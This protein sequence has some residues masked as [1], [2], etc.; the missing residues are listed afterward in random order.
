MTKSMKAGLYACAALL[1]TPAAAFTYTYEASDSSFIL[2]PKFDPNYG[3]LVSI[4]FE[5]QFDTTHFFGPFE[6]PQTI[7]VVGTVGDP[8]L[9]LTAVD[10]YLTS[11][12]SFGYNG[13]PLIAITL[14]TKVDRT[15]S[16]DLSAYYAGGTGFGGVPY[17]FIGDT[18]N[19]VFEL[20]NGTRVRDVAV[21]RNLPF[22]S[23]K[24]TYEFTQAAVVP[25][26]ATWALM[27][28][29][30]GMIGYSLRRRAK[31]LYAA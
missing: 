25:E 5:N 4:R 20:P 19:Q 23:T 16:G 6:M 18:G 29:G 10:Q 3:T 13:T 27:L 21:S 8:G 15:Y 30:F 14:S 26:P 9:G 31:L 12:T 22:V 1:S 7:H 28:A 11:S 2:A 17:L 24:I